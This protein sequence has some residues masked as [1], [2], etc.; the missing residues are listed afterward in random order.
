LSYS[1]ARGAFAGV[2]LEGS[3]IRPDNDANERIYGS[4]IPARDIVLRDAAPVP[5]S[6]RPMI[7]TLDA[8]T[9]HHK[10]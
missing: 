5:P 6:A 8:R 1:R 3:T 2:S 10:S 9:P 4:K 7:A